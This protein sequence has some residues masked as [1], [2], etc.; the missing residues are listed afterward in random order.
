MRVNKGKAV[1]KFLRFY[2]VVY[3][4]GEPYDVILD[5]NFIFFALKN[6]V[7]IRE[8]LKKLLQ[9]A[10]VRLY[11]LK[12]VVEELENVGAKTADALSFVKQFCTVIADEENVASA[13]RKRPRGNEEGK[14]GDEEEEDTPL[15]RMQRMFERLLRERLEGSDRA[16]TS[17][18]YF[19]ASQ[20]K[21]LRATLARI[22]G[23]PLI[24]LNKVNLVL[25]PPSD[26][27]KEFN[28]ELEVA[29]VKLTNNEAQM[30]EVS[31]A[32]AKGLKVVVDSQGGTLA[33]VIVTGPTGTGQQP[34]KERKKKKAVAANPLSNRQAS[35]DSKKSK[36]RKLDA[37]RRR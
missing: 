36:K 33:D 6:K 5:G 23:V 3:E 34:P 12:S 27:S 24:Y 32:R 7:D 15:K 2:K 28:R 19:V 30:V 25:E 26:A 20:D 14:V 37:V 4:I 29:K 13:S 22:P 17:K 21:L 9:G 16:K 10:L 11:V 1:R 8:R 18:K 31:K 35:E